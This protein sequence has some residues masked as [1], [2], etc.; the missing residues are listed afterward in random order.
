MIPDQLLLEDYARTVAERARDTGTEGAGKSSS[1]WMLSAE[2]TL[3]AL[4]RS[5]RHFT[6]EDVIAV[7]GPA[8]APPAVG[9]LFLRAS[10]AR[11]I[12]H[13]G[14]ESAK[15]IQAHARAIRVWRGCR[16]AP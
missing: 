10:R 1:E 5:G 14:F 7:V 12:E 9:A 13:V 8:P 16:R 15:R 4:I 2:G 6:S 11:L 3:E